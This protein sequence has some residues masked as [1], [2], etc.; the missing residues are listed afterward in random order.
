[1]ERAARGRLEREHRSGTELVIL[2]CPSSAAYI[3]VRLSLHHLRMLSSTAA[4]QTRWLARGGPS[5]GPPLVCS[6]KNTNILQNHNIMFESHS[7]RLTTGHTDVE[8]KLAKPLLLSNN[9]VKTGF[10]LSGDSNPR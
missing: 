10:A 9:F 7:H 3:R 6:S 2:T 8:L 4:V 5:E 1:M